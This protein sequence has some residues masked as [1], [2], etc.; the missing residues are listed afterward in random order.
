M[1]Q[2]DMG[3][4]QS[5][6]WHRLRRQALHD[7]GWKCQR[8]GVSLLGKPREAQVHHRKPR[9]RAPGL[10]LE[11]LNL[12]V[13]CRRCHRV[14][15]N[16]G[17]LANPLPP[18]CVSVSGDPLDPAHPWNQSRGGRVENLIEVEPSAARASFAWNRSAGYFG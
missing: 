2:C 17:S 14:A 16:T 1:A 4:L 15:H 10:L 3:F 13:L 18:L 9:D 5:A 7:A 8:C 11:Q 12:E 6:R